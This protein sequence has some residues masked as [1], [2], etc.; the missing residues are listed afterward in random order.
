MAI[1]QLGQL[2]FEVRRRPFAGITVP[3]IGEHDAA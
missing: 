1:F 3:T 2:Q